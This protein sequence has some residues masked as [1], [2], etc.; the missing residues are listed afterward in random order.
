MSIIFSSGCSGGPWR[1]CLCESGGQP[2]PVPGRLERGLRQHG[3]RATL[4]VQPD[5][6]AAVAVLERRHPAT[7]IR[8]FLL[9]R[10]HDRC[11][12]R[13]RIFVESS[14][15]VELC[16]QRPAT[17]VLA[18]A[19]RCYDHWHQRGQQSRRF[20]LCYSLRSYVCLGNRCSVCCWCGASVLEV[21]TRLCRLSEQHR[22]CRLRTDTV[23]FC[24]TDSDHHHCCF[25]QGLCV[26]RPA[27]YS[28]SVLRPECRCL[29]S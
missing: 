17:L 4:D 16:G 21:I 26:C 18:G 13:R 2:W 1:E 7:S 6:R 29:L 12:D 19:L 23:S 9:P 25:L 22:R 24:S 3:R 11:P 20:P 8:P 15:T 10:C 28:Y 5:A 27:D 14:T